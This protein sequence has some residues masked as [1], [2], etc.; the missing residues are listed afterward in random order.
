VLVLSGLRRGRAMLYA[1]VVAV[2]LVATSLVVV[3]TPEV[4][5][6]EVT[7][8]GGQ[9]ASAP[10]RVLDT[11]TDI[12]GMPGVFTPNTWRGVKVTGVG[13][14]PA[15][16]VGAV[17]V[18]VTAVDPGAS[19][20]VHGRPDASKPTTLVMVYEPQNTSNTATL[21]VSKDG[22]IELLAQTSVHLVVDVQG[23]YTSTENG[24]ADGGFV[25][26]SGERLADTRNGT[27]ITKG[28]IAP[29]STVTTQVTGNA[30][31]PVGASAVVA[32][33]IVINDGST[34]GNFTPY[35][36]GSTKPSMA[37]NYTTAT[38]VPRSMSAQI[39][40]SA[41]GKISITNV[42]G[43]SP[44]SLVIDIQ[45]YFTKTAAGGV[46]TPQT[47]RLLDTRET[48]A[49]AANGTLSVQVAGARRGVPSVDGGL[50]AV[51]LTLTNVNA[52]TSEGRAVAW[53][54][55]S[56]QPNPYTSINYAP[57][58]I[59]SNAVIVP[60]GANGKINLRNISSV[61]THFVLD[62]QGT[63][64]SLP[65]GPETTGLTGSRPSA[66]NLSFG[67]SDQTSAQVDVATGNLMLSTTGL[68]A[69]GVSSSVPF[70]LSY[71]SRGHQAADSNLPDANRWQYA[72]GA[73]GELSANSKG[74]VY[75]GADGSTW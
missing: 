7:G 8:T 48:A 12:G 60:V 9:Y 72:L 57:Q 44:I 41:D 53:A 15:E 34:R 3:G 62:L 20:Q 13:G 52:T 38:G 25:P 23:Y 74:V 6:A 24:V 47:G 75:T 5:R 39:P 32:N 69:P 14:V 43:G 40:V 36:A 65:T 70:G 66:T 31:V 54:D 73:A 46:Y 22:K 51:A 29:D 50:T 68:S 37:L 17:S 67:I 56:A 4:A 26:V 21:A 35:A 16:N 28:S 63:Y 42:A 19:A 30:G 27:G 10:V 59:R 11:R 2:S 71:N 33:F 1:A 45:G 58:S 55:G 49:V 64:N 18:T 61:A